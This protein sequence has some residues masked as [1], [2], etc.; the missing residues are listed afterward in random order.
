[1]GD[2]V[3]CLRGTSYQ[4]VHSRRHFPTRIGSE[5]TPVGFKPTPVVSEPT[6][7]VSEPTPVVPEPTPVVSEPTPVG[8]EPTSV[9][10]EPAPGGLKLI[11]AGHRHIVFGDNQFSFP[12]FTPRARLPHHLL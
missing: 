6:P 9:V 5:P 11:D 8:F 10:S 1:M 7:V 2:G 4:G 12:T 3:N